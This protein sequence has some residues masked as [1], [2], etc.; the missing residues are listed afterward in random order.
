[1]T[2]PPTFFIPGVDP[3]RAESAWE[4]YAAAV[5]RPLPKREDRIYSLVF[6]HNQETWTAT[7]GEKL[8]GFSDE[9]TRKGL[10][11]R[12]TRQLSDSATVLVILGPNPFLVFT[13]KQAFP[14]RIRSAW[15]NPFLVGDVISRVNFGGTE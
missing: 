10:R 12:Q 1:M 9:R 14:P 3:A 6:R 13:D 8:S 7:V 11:Q 2:P 15:E 4:Q 5:G